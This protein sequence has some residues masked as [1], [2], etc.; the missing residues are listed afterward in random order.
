VGYDVATAVR[1]RKARSEEGAAAVEFALILPIL[2]ALLIGIISY[3]WMM[4]FRQA[5]SQAA[6]EG[7]RHAAVTP[8]GTDAEKLADAIDIVDDALKGYGT[9]CGDGATSCPAV[10]K[11]C[12]NNTAKRCAYV[13][14]T[15]PYRD[16]P[17]IPSFPGLG[18]TLP[19]TLSY[20]AVAEVS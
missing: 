5:M 8:S 9:K 6:A 2:M 1:R 3:G 19:Q 12:D 4:S 20:T 10:I 17:L 15:Y 16:Q 7:A 14:V 11:A 13:T 18:A